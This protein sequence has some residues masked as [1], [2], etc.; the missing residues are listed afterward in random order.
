[1]GMALQ[2][3]RCAQCGELFRGRKDAEYCAN[4]CRQAAYRERRQHY[5]EAED[6]ALPIGSAELLELEQQTQSSYELPQEAHVNGDQDPLLTGTGP[7]L[8]LTPPATVG[9][10]AAAALDGVPFIGITG[11][12]AHLTGAKLARTIMEAVCSV[13]AAIDVD[14]GE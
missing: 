8:S 10:V 6:T 14:E 9:P 2:M 1:M 12:I 3:R 11:P 4:A 5:I 13:G 7:S